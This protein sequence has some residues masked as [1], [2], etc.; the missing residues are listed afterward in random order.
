MS[1]RSAYTG[2]RGQLESLAAIWSQERNMATLRSPACRPP[3]FVQNSQAQ[4]LK[5]SMAFGARHF[6]VQI[7][8]L[9]LVNL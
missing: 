3:W 7:S 6:Y 9:F 8:I 1:G 2:H 5:K 4:V